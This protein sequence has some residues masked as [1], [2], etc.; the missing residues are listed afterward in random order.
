MS[1]RIRRS[2]G[3]RPGWR[4]P[5]SDMRYQQRQRRPKRRGRGT[6]TEFK[7]IT[8]GLKPLSKREV[9]NTHFHFEGLAIETV[10]QLM[11]STEKAEP[12]IL[13]LMP[14]RSL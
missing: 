14:R 13:L 12:F 10:E 5:E 11:P 8:R 9:S 7:R 1:L 2:W 6:K 3:R 4:K